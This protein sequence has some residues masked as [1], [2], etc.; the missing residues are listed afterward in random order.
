MKTRCRIERRPVLAE[1]PWPAD[2]HPVLRRVYARRPLRGVA[3]L[4][5]GL[6]GLLDAD[7]LSGLARAVELLEA[8]LA[9][10]R[11]IL[12]VGDFDADGATAAALAVRGLRALGAAEVDVLVPDRFRFGYGLSPEIVAV[13]AE[14]RPDL[15]ITVDTASPASRVSPRRARRACR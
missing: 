3:E 15:L 10:R 6:M 9:G 11:R 4:D 12:V 13:A 2:L 5:H 7:R 8:A 14:R 1:L